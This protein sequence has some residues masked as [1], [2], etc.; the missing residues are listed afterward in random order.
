MDEK[1]K[2]EIRKQISNHFQEEKLSTLKSGDYKKCPKCGDRMNV[3]SRQTRK[4]D[5]G[6]TI[7]YMCNNPRCLKNFK[8]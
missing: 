1:L 4:A 6:M 2:I 8:V 3:H 7:F 5:E